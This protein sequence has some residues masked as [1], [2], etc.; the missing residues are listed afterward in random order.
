MQAKLPRGWPGAH[1]QTALPSVEVVTSRERGVRTM[2]WRT[3]WGQP[4]R[5][6]ESGREFRRKVLQEEDQKDIPSHTVL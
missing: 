5:L 3:P 2:P 1:D 4:S 6:K